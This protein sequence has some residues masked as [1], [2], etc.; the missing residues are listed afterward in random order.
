M[1][2][3]STAAT[4]TM[5]FTNINDRNILSPDYSLQFAAGQFPRHI[6]SDLIQRFIAMSSALGKTSATNYLAEIQ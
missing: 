3:T 2:I 6:P 5:D 1:E 4:S